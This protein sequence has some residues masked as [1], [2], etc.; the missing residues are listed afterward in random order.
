MHTSRISHQT[1]PQKYTSE[2]E[3]HHIIIVEASTRETDG[4][5]PKEGS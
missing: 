5:V 3:A 2:R 4:V 1:H